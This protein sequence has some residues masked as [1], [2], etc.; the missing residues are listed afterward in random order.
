MSLVFLG[1][2]V[3]FSYSWIHIKG[4]LAGV[5]CPEL[6]RILKFKHSEDFDLF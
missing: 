2:D 1:L 6:L 3:E 4:N 5:E